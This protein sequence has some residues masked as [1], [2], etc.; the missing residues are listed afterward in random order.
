MEGQYNP[1]QVGEA[2]LDRDTRGQ[3]SRDPLPPSGKVERAMTGTRP[4]ENARWGGSGFAVLA[5]AKVVAGVLF[6][7]LFRSLWHGTRE[8]AE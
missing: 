5:I 6:E 3:N 2:Y 1:V 7:R 4:S 8:S